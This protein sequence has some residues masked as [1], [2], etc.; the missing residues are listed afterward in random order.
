[1]TSVMSATTLM[2]L[3][4]ESGRSSTAERGIAICTTQGV[5]GT[6]ALAPSISP[7]TGS[8]YITGP[9]ANLSADGW[10]E[11]S[12]VVVVRRSLLVF[13]R[14]RLTPGPMI[15]RSPRCAVLERVSFASR[16][17]C[18]TKPL[19]MPPCV[20]GCTYHVYTESPRA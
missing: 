19:V 15:S 3:R 1:M 2:R 11:S 5:R 17:R 13:A 9:R 6:A 4:N 7:V 10:S 18:A 14:Y 20:T 16:T 12:P 8:R